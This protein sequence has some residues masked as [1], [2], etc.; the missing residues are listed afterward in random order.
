MKL[1]DAGAKDVGADGA[2]P[3]IIAGV[4]EEGDVRLREFCARRRYSDRQ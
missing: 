1:L 3:T 2:P 4:R